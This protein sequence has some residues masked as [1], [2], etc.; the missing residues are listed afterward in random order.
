MLWNWALKDPA[1]GQAAGNFRILTTFSQT[2]TEERFYEVPCD[3]EALGAPALRIMAAIRNEAFL[4]DRLARKRMAAYLLQLA[5][6]V[7]RIAD[8]FPTFLPEC[9]PTVF[10]H[11]SRPWFH[12]GPRRFVMSAEDRSLDTVLDFGGPSAGQATLIHVRRCVQRL[13]DAAVA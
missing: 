8:I 10:Y 13:T 4:G 6:L 11:S 2:R 5:T 9:D 1:L 7:E 12:G 3:M